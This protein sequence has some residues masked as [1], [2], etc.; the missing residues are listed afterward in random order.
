MKPPVVLTTVG[1][2]SEAD[3]GGLLHRAL[4]RFRLPR[5]MTSNIERT[6]AL[7]R[8]ERLFQVNF[9]NTWTR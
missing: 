4:S 2:R 3:S 9:R 6:A 5:R 8:A 1:I 7:N